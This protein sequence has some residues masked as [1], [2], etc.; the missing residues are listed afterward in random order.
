MLVSVG[1]LVL[2]LCG[3]AGLRLIL[4]LK[5]VTD[6]GDEVDAVTDAFIVD[7]RDGLSAAGFDGLCTQAKEMFRPQDLA[8]PGRDQ[9]AATGHR[10]TS[11][12]V[13]HA[14]GQATVGVEFGFA[15]GTTKQE[16]Y[17]L[18]KQDDTWKVCLFPS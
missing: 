16:I 9:Q 5:H 18:E 7:S 11:T 1:V 13:E 15:D 10:I 12:D 14:R 6:V 2:A 8:V 3:F 4:N 17:I